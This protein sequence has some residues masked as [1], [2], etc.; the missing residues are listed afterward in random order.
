MH[1]LTNIGAAEFILGVAGGREKLERSLELARE[2]GLE[3][4]VAAAFC[5]LAR[6]AA[7]TRAH[8]L[9]ESYANAGI[10]YCSEHDLDGWRPFLIAVRGEVELDQGRWGEAAESAALV[11]AGHGLGP[12]SVSALV[13]LGRLRARR[14][15]PGQWAP[16]DEALELAERSGELLRLGPVAAARAEAAWLEGRPDGVAETTGAMFELAQQRKDRWLIGELAYWRWRAGIEE[17]IPPGAAEPYAAPDRRRLETRGGPLGGARLSLR[18]RARARGRRRRRDPSPCPRRAAATGRSAGGGD[19]RAPPARARRPRAAAR[20]APRNP[21]EPRQP[22]RAR[23]RD[24]GARRAGAAK[25][26]HRGAA[27]PLRRG[28]SPTTSPRSCASSRSARA[29]RRA[30]RPCGSGIAGQDR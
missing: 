10:E 13:T 25:H 14:G 27:L 2:A 26:G 4:R 19:R 16:L 9:A 6:G 12:A 7:H 30:P 18:A 3:E 8:A 20:T 17:E 1:A 15:D 5:Y 24:P 22:D 29:A 23:A 21:A 28:R 11:L